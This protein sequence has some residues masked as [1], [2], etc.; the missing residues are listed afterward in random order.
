MYMISLKFTSKIEKIRRNKWNEIVCNILVTKEEV[1][2]L[3][4][5]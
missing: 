1:E 2:K 5:H 4:T 3:F